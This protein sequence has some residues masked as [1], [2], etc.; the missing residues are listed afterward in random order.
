VELQYE[1]LVF[2]RRKANLCIRSKLNPGSKASTNDKLN[3]TEPESH[4]GPF[5]GEASAL[6][7]VECLLLQNFTRTA[8]LQS[9]AFDTTQVSLQ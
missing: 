5:G 2:V 7:S 1:V 8:S 4:P 9:I 3:R 6:T